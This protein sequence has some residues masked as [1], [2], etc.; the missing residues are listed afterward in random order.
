MRTRYFRDSNGQPS[1]SAAVYEI[2]DHGISRNLID[3]DARKICSRLK[4]Q[5]HQAFIV[6]GAVRDLL[7]GR[8]PKD[9]DIATDA[10]PNRVKRLFRNSRIIGK[11]FRLVHI[12]FHDGKIHEVATF[13]AI[14][15]GNRNHIY[16]TLF[17]DVMRRDFSVNALYFDPDDQTI[18]DFIGGVE[19]I[20]NKIIRSV[21]PLESSFIEDPVRMLRAVKYAAITGMKIAAPV[22]RKIKKQAPLL[23]SASISR[24]SEELNK[25]FK[26]RNIESIFRL[27][28]RYKLIACILPQFENIFRQAN[29]NTLK[30]NF[31][32]KLAQLDQLMLEKDVERGEILRYLTEDLLHAGGAF[33]KSD[34]YL[35]LFNEVVH[36]LRSLLRPLVQPNRDVEEAVRQMFINRGLKYP[37][38]RPRHPEVRAGE[39]ERERVGVNS[40]NQRKRQRRYSKQSNR[41]NTR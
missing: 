36:E 15:S 37:R 19:D 11:R 21:L 17:E 29:T 31:F 10:P 27:M 18:I 41:G 1:I 30:E 22:G 8:S 4:V 16:G 5:G 7:L 40:E 24:L 28:D 20:K 25:I 35:L 32:L 2:S 38:K 14:E 12:Y 6:G 26:S 3:L 39:S 13:R 23:S 33:K 34:Q 9:F